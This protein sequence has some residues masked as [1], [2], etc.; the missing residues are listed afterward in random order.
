MCVTMKNRWATKERKFVSHLL[1]GI[2]VLLCRPK[3][4]L[5]TV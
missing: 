5:Q 3:C 2:L 1:D 4:D